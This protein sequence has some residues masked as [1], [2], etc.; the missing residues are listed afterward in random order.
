MRATHLIRQPSTDEG[1]FGVLT[2]D[3]GDRFHSGELPWRYNARGVS[4]V[5]PGKY[6]CVIHESRRFGRCYIL[7]D[8]KNRSNILI[9]RGNWCGDKTLGFKT[10]VLGCILL[11]TDEGR[12]SGQRAV[13][14][15]GK[16][17]DLFMRIMDG[18]D[19]ELTIE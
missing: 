13:L 12:L 17:M 14:N 8:V 18:D 10:D 9:H 15:S 2:L 7:K 1:T 3:T 6:R 4:C 5:P 19:F 11:G 16:A